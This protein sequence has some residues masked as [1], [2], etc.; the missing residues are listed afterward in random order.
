MN[1][2]WLCFLLFSCGAYATPAV[3]PASGLAVGEGLEIV[4]AHCSG[5]HSVKLVTQNRMSRDNWL[6]TI[7]WMQKTQGLWPLGEHEK[8][9]L[10]YLEKYYSP[11]QTGRRAN[12]PTHLLP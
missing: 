5:C 8:T 1:R 9:I 4:R 7:R 6:Q 11:L 10:D 3:D 12:L 2:L